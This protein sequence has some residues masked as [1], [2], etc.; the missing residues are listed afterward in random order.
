MAKRRPSGDGLVRKRADGRWEG[1]IVIGKKEDG[2]PIFQSVFANTQK[3]L[4]VKLHQSIELYRDVEVTE[5]RSM[6]LEAWLDKWLTSYTSLTLRPAT[7]ENYRN[8]I[9]KYI[10][11]RLGNEPLHSLTTAQ[12]QKMY[13]SLKK[14]GRIHEHPIH[15]SELSDSMVRHIHMVL[16]QALEAA[17]RERLIVRNPTNGT[18]IPRVNHPP[19]QVLNQAQLDAFLAVLKEDT[20]WYD[21]FYTELTTGLRKGEIC[22][23]RWTDLNLETGE[24]HINRT[25]HKG[26]GGELVVGKPKTSASK[27]RIFLPPSTLALL[28]KRKEHSVSEWI[29][30]DLL[31]PERC[32]N[33]DSAYHR[34]KTLLKA[35]GCPQIRFHDLRHTFATHALTS[36]VDA[37]TLSGILGHTNAS[38]TLDTYTHV[39]G[40]MQQSA[41]RVVGGMMDELLGGIM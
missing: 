21:F 25:L 37:K 35:A 38:F 30:P 6:T 28:R 4:L 3:E 22:S 13:N 15:S 12:I 7:V 16:H 19:K 29:F 5:Q 11:P 20:L 17:V 10:N 31:K 33:P 32:M 41:A 9:E 34:M 27:R 8:C 2:K 24:L 23:L 18:V 39:T 14:Y 40:D 26:H 1:R 36:G